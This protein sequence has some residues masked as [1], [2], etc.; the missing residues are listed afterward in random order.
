MSYFPT[1]LNATEGAR[2]DRLRLGQVLSFAEEA[3]CVFW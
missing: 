1:F 2:R 3:G